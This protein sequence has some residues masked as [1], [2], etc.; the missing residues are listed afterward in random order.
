MPHFIALL[1]ALACG[2]A[3]AAQVAL[4]GVIGDKAA[5]LSLDGGDPKTV[6]VGQ[7]WSWRSRT[8]GREE[9]Q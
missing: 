4:I 1:L 7:K 6:R 9:A 8:Q 5:V 3:S 2:S